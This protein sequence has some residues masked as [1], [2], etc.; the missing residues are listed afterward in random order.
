LFLSD[1]SECR[2]LIDLYKSDI[3]TVV[4]LRQYNEKRV[5][6]NRRAIVCGMRLRSS[7]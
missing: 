4:A 5:D 1:E 3:L 7:Y 6:K 2:T